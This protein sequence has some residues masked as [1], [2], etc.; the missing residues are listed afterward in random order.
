MRSAVLT[1]IDLPFE[2]HHKQS[3]HGSSVHQ[4]IFTRQ[5]GCRANIRKQISEEKKIEKRKKCN[6]KKKKK[7]GDG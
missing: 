2:I 6:H 5:S 7:G 3:P 4:Q 1:A